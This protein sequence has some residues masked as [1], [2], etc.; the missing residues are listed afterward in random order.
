MYVPPSNDDGPPSGESSAVSRRSMLA[1]TGLAVATAGCIR[2]ARNAINREQVDQ[3]SVTI[4]TLPS[5]SD[6]ESIQLARA[7]RD[8]LETAGIDASLRIRPSE[9]YLRTVLVNH[10][11]E[12][13]VG[14]YPGGTDPAILYE[15][16]HS[17]YA[18]EAGWQNP[19][20]LTNLA[21]DDAL[22][23]QRLADGDERREAIE[24]TLEAFVA[25]QPFVPICAPSEYRLVRGDR[26]EGW[27]QFHPASPLGYLGLEGDDDNDRLRA[28]HTDPRPS[29]NLNPLSVEYRDRG[30][31]TGLLYDSLAVDAA[32]ELVENELPTAGDENDDESETRRYRP[33]LAD[34]WEWD[35]H[36]E[37][38]G[39]LTVRL[40]D[41]CWFHDGEPVTVEDVVFT[42]R[43]LADT[44][45]GEGA[46]P[47]PTPRHRGK[48]APVE[49]LERL[50]DDRLE[51]SIAG[52]RDVA[53]RALTVP[54]LPEH[55]WAERSQAADVRGVQIAD[56]TT[57]A[58]VVDNV[59]AVGS[60]PFAFVE[61]TEREHVT[62]ER[63]EEHFTLQDGVDL[64]APTV[65]EV[66]VTI[67]PRSTSAVELVT[68]DDADVTTAAL[69]SYV[70]DGVIETTA[71]TEE[72]ELLGPP[73]RAFYYLGF[74][75]R[76]APFS[77]PRFRRT[78]ARLLD[79]TWLAE[80]VFDGHARP[81]T[82][83]V[84]DEWVPEDL[85]FDG[86]DPTT[87]FL[88]TAGDG[89]IDV[90][91]TRAA[92]EEVGYSYDAAGRLRVRR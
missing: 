88:G 77:N 7:I 30:L 13:C 52:G 57:E 49:D 44:T 43:F 12:L 17:Q 92:F 2:E 84:A 53:E 56:G 29:W 46:I 20:G 32:D 15:A 90:E 4:T 79:K 59:P 67:D 48:I 23:R 69:E 38:G 50:D 18:D 70:V 75:A 16:L 27:G 1:A 85:A 40:R 55:V 58:V 86:D 54:I 34:G 91:A 39:T 21:V 11:F 83:P 35:E 10:D 19:F 82:V 33:W 81:I 24:A 64:P 22:E 60:G 63:H 26:F 78:V 3:L 80:E 89:E 28:V 37:N 9:E 42:Y 71:E 14:R 87:P 8:V 51:L 45:R 47:S 76:T 5:D 41:D 36:D 72:L 68:D 61:R 66:R 73:S 25:E 6:R 31:F 65:E 62:L 74:N